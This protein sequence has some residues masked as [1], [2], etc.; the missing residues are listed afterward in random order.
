VSPIFPIILSVFIPVFSVASSFCSSSLPVFFPCSC[1]VLVSVFLF[2]DHSA[3]PDHATACRSV[4]YGLWS[5]LLTSACPWPV[6]LP[7]PCSSNKLL[8]LWHCLHLG[9]LLKHDSL[10]DFSI[11]SFN[12]SL[13]FYQGGCLV[14]WP[15]YT[16]SDRHTS[17]WRCITAVIITKL[18]TLWCQ[19]TYV[20]L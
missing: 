3:C 4:P 6:T 5:G 17:Q 18:S 1:L 20:H 7:A 16:K 2:F 13:T 15:D 8:L 19:T 11:P 10:L 12:T 14:D 9:L